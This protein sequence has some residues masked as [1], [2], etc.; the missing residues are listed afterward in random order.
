[1]AGGMQLYEA[2][3]DDLWENSI[4]IQVENPCYDDSVPKRE[5]NISVSLED[6]KKCLADIETCPMNE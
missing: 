5:V 6:L 1:M 3:I 2:N 4:V